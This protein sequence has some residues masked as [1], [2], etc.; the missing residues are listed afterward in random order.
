MEAME[1]HGY[2]CLNTETLTRIGDNNQRSSNI[3]LILCTHDVPDI[4]DYQQGEDPW[5]SDHFPL[6]LEIKTSRIT[7][8]KITNR[9]STKKNGLGRIPQMDGSENQATKRRNRYFQQL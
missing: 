3:D 1:D 8:H 5:G 7:Y 2:I 6:I 9:L 4:M